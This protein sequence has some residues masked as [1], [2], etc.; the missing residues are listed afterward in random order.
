MESGIRAVASNI[1]EIEGANKTSSLELE[2]YEER[3]GA[4]LGRFWQLVERDGQLI[5]VREFDDGESRI[6][7]DVPRRNSQTEPFVNVTVAANGDYSTFSPELLGTS[8]PNYPTFTLGNVHQGG[9]LSSV[10]REPFRSL[11][12]DIRRGVDAC[13]DE[14]GY[15]AVCGGGN[16]SNKIAENGDA[17]STETLN[18]RARVKASASFLVDALMSRLEA[19]S[20]PTPL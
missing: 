16:P 19:G 6:L 13:R 15:F 7:Q 17:A 4:F 18:C 10:E 2:D 8:S 14:C 12:G 9:F 20:D 5:R 11:W 3:Y 1:E